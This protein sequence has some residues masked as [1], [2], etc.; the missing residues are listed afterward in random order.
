MFVVNDICS[1]VLELASCLLTPCIVNGHGSFHQAP[2]RAFRSCDNLTRLAAGV[3]T[4]AQVAV[5]VYLWPPGVLFCCPG[6]DTLAFI[7]LAT[8]PGPLSFASDVLQHE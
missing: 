1:S 4:F 2:K 7:F 5:A 6:T 8:S 3:L